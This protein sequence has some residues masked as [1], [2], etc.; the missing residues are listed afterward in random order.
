M[1]TESF[2]ASDFA[3]GTKRYV[4]TGARVHV[5][6]RVPKVKV[7]DRAREFWRAPD[8]RVLRLDIAQDDTARVGEFDEIKLEMPCQIEKFEMQQAW[9]LPFEGQS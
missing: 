4:S 8:S 2:R 6:L 3:A 7:E 9:H 1:A 5:C